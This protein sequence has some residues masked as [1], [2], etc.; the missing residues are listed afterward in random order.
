MQLSDSSFLVV[1]FVWDK[2]WPQAIEHTVIIGIQLGMTH[3]TSLDGV[4]DIAWAAI[5][6]CPPF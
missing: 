6:L 1:H 2:C 5:A 3:A 4:L